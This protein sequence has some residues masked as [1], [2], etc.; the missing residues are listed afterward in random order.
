MVNIF[1]ASGFDPKRDI[2]GIVLDRR[3]QSLV[4]P[5]RAFV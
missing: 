1:R 5:E 2:A 4:V 3:G